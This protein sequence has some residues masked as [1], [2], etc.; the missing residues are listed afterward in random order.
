MRYSRS[1]ANKAGKENLTPSMTRKAFLGT[2]A[3]ALGASVFGGAAK[4]LA[5]E[6]ELLRPP[7]VSD[8]AEFASKCLR[9]YRCIEVCHTNALVPATLADG[10]LV[11][12][13][14]TFDFH[15]GSCDFCGDC[16]EVCP[17][18]AII[19]GDPYSPAEG[20]IGVAVIQTDR[21][22]AYFNG[23]QL[24]QQ[25]CPYEAISLSNDGSPVIDET[26]CNGCG[27]C[28]NVCPALV[29]RSFSG[30]NRRGVVVVKNEELARAM[31]NSLAEEEADDETV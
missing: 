19:P 29:Y 20:R 26:V 28:E 5:G 16:A 10:I 4:A 2:A 12:R 13:T 11:A 3:T 9:C 7:L 14:P 1:L 24:C 18:N 30:G 6:G 15:K 17:T 23:C 27:V 22:V 31:R 21:C 8:E 25:A